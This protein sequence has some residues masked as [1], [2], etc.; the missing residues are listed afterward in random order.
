MAGKL[1]YEELE[2]K[3]KELE[4]EAARHKASERT[5]HQQAQ[6]LSSIKDTIVVITPEMKTIY[7][8]QTA[9]K[10]FGDRPEM[11]TEPCYRFFKNR[12]TVC[13]NCPV[14]KTIKDEKP[15]KAIMGLGSN[16]AHLDGGT[17]K[18]EVQI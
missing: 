13:E 9:K 17:I 4:L 7:A 5:R 14:L 6:I 16:F 3:I 2:R 10:L 18:K 8:N 15:H 12:E 1:T 11:F